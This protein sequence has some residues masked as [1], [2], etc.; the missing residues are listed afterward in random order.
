MVLCS[1]VLKKI[2][3]KEDVSYYNNEVYRTI[4][5]RTITE[6][7][8]QDLESSVKSSNITYDKVAYI[9]IDDGPSKFTNQILDILDKNDVKATFFMI[10]RNMNTYKDEVKRIQQEGHGAGFHSVSHDVKHYIRHHN[11][12]LRSFLYVGIH[13]KK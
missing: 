10:N 4:K 6:I 11:L 7:I 2:F 5:T 3:L 13:L 12:H 9:T 1:L 8:N